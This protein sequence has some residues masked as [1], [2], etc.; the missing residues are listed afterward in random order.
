MPF[1]TPEET[2]DEDVPAV[3]VELADGRVWGLALPG[4]RLHPITHREVDPFGRPH[5]RIE[6]VTR[7]GYPLEV[8]RLWDEVVV[9]LSSENARPRE[10]F[11]RLAIALLR[12]VHEVG[13]E[14]AE[15]LLDPARVDLW[16]L[17]ETFIPAAFGDSVPTHPGER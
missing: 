14:E 8:R 13:Q 16:Q 7:V 10:P 2:R 5:V 3:E 17:A 12:I 11:R 6:L 9:P 15:A 4:P 1:P